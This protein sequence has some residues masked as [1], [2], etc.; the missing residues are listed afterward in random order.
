M[1]SQDRLYTREAE[2]AAAFKFEGLLDEGRS[3]WSAEGF[4][5]RVHSTNPTKGDLRPSLAARRE[6]AQIVVASRIC[7]PS[8]DRLRGSHGM[9]QPA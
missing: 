6:R 7:A 1:V 5:E 9:D 8:L 2:L 3:S 4:T